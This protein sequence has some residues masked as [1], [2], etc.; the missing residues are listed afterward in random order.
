[1]SI[2]LVE[3]GGGTIALP[4]PHGQGLCVTCRFWAELPAQ[5]GRRDDRRHGQCRRY[6]PRDRSG[7]GSLWPVM[8]GRQW[9]GEHA[10][11]PGEEGAT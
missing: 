11:L 9:C 6:P 7:Q 10:A 2:K 8:Q 3:K 1:M 5:D 4:A